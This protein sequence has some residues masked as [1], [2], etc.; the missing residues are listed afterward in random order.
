MI[1]KTFLLFFSV[2][3]L[4]SCSDDDTN[5]TPEQ[6]VRIRLSNISTVDFKN[7]TFD[8][9]NFGDLNRAEKTG[10]KKLENDVYQYG[11]VSIEINDQNYGWQPIDFVGQTPLE[12]GDYT[13]EY[14]FDVETQT[15]T[16]ELIKD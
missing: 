1:K 7:A 4:F 14:N 8:F 6:N 3:L 12:D 10:Y 15:L 16:D 9:V 13:F 5:D 2:L 11:S